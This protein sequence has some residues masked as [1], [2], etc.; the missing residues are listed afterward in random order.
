MHNTFWFSFIV[1]CMVSAIAISKVLERPDLCQTPVYLCRV[2]V[3]KTNVILTFRICI[4]HFGPISLYLCMVSAIAIS[5][6]LERPDRCQTPVY[7]CQVLV[8][9]TCVILTFWDGTGILITQFHCFPCVFVYFLH[10][11]HPP[12]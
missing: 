10:L 2:L 6:V 11:P 12:C 4:T 8:F 9:K 1:F 5:K 3:V 7:Q